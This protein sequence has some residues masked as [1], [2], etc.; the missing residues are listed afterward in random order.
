MEIT[1]KLDALLEK[2]SNDSVLKD[3]LLATRQS[4]NPI[5]DFCDI[6][7]EYGIQISVMDIVN[8]GEEFY[9][10]IKRSTNGGGENS[11]DLDFQNDEYSIFMMRLH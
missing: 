2:A 6:A 4:P 8:Q 1:E 10:E 3:K 5:A 11:P 7:N 9:A